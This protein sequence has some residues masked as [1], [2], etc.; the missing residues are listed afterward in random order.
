M[1][2]IFNK[3]FYKIVD[4]PVPS[5][6]KPTTRFPKV[7]LSTCP[8]QLR[9]GLLFPETENENVAKV[10]CGSKTGKTVKKRTKLFC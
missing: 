2:S 1:K 5:T 4:I 9:E 6:I 3:T 10:S 7:Q 8:E